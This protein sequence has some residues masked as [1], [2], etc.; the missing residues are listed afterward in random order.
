MNNF[1]WYELIENNSILTQG[2][3]LF[4]VSVPE[5]SPSE[6]EKFTD[7]SCEKAKDLRSSIEIIDGIVLTQACDLANCKVDS[8]IL[9]GITKLDDFIKDQIKEKKS[10]NNIK[11]ILG[12]I[13]KGQQHSYHMLD[14]FHNDSFSMDY[15]IV[16]FREIYR[17]PLDFATSLTTSSYNKKRLRLLP[18]YREHLSQAFA[19]FFMRVGL[20]NNIDQ[21]RF[22]EAITHSF[23]NHKQ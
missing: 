9:V 20:P 10:L 3:I 8:V 17:I 2:D 11:S 14:S 13:L 19:R 15:L 6:F 1:S 18:P 22:N 16:N 23:N 12:S 5:I 4:N 7:S 21:D